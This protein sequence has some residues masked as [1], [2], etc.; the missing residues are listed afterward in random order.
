MP[1]TQHDALVWMSGSAYDVVFDMVRS[2]VR[3][4]AGLADLGQETSSWSYRKRSGNHS[5]STGTLSW[6]G[7]R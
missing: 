3:D 1:S 6:Q 5:L 2:V 4:L 7:A